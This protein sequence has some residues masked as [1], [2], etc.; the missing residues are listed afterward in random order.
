MNLA[1]RLPIL[2]APLF[3]KGY[4]SRALGVQPGYMIQAFRFDEASGTTANSVKKTNN[5]GSFESQGGGNFAYRQAGPAGTYAIH[6]DGVNVCIDMINKAGNT[7]ATDWNG[8]LYSAIC[9]MKVDSAAQWTDANVRYGW[10][11]RSN[12]DDT[13]YTVMGKFSDN[14]KL[15]WRRRTGL[16]TE[17]SYTFSPAGPLDWFCMGIA[18]N[19]SAPL[20]DFY[21]WTSALGFKKLTGSTSANLTA[22]G[23]NPP[24]ISKAVIGAGSWSSQEWIGYH[25][26]TITWAGIKLSDAEMRRAM[27]PT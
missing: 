11:V 12:L 1:S 25:S 2:S 6:L 9:W 4:L 22:W 3:K 10:H 8:D 15:F 14:H 27:T 26:L 21:L 13:Y 24:G 5:D 19:Q 17:Q 16:I 7:F 18:F 20:L 23:N